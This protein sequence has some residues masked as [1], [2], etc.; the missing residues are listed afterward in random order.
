MSIEAWVTFVLASA[1]LLTT[2]GPT[3]MVAVSHALNRGRLAAWPIVLGATFLT[4]A[5]LNI[6]V[7]VFLASAARTFLKSPR[8]LGVFNTISGAFL[9]AF[10][11][12]LAFS[13]ARQK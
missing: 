4:L 1:L 2:P 7:W 6:T 8:T 5:A 10:G 3:V 9:I 12:T 11:T 13:D